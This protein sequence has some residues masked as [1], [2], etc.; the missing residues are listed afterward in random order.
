[1]SVCLYTLFQHAVSGN[2]PL[3]KRVHQ[4][5]LDLDGHVAMA[6]LDM[7]S[8]PANA[9]IPMGWKHVITPT[10]TLLQ[11][12]KRVT[13]NPWP[14]H[15]KAMHQHSRAAPAA[16]ARQPSLPSQ[17]PQLQRRDATKE[18]RPAVVSPDHSVATTHMQRANTHQQRN[19]R[20]IYVLYVSHCQ[21][22]H[23]QA[24]RLRHRH[25]AE[26]P[27]MPGRPHLDIS[28]GTDTDFIDKVAS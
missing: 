3:E 10:C 2:M 1:M 27:P 6:M 28:T 11:R 4:N 13:S 17:A 5:T 21:R 22:P 8:I 23:V 20:A 25:A 18:F 24:P 19:K 16:A 15:G 26:S 14:Q 9:I 7:S 12:S